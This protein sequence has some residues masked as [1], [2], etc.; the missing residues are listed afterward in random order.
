MVSVLIA[1]FNL[2]HGFCFKRQ[3]QHFPRFLFLSSDQPRPWFLCLAIDRMLSDSSETAYIRK[4]KM[5]GL[6][7][8]WVGGWVGLWVGWWVG[9]MVGGW[10][11]E[12]MLF[13]GLQA[14]IYAVAKIACL[15]VGW[16]GRGL[17][18]LDLIIGN[19]LWHK[20]GQSS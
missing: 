6:V 18:Q 8:E 11:V 16:A 7:G 12:G 3:F 2:D 4:I 19:I 5:G 15:K 13:M 9:R 14:I 20:G 17:V 1:G 10:V